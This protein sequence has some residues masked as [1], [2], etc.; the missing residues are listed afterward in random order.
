MRREGERSEEKKGAGS[1]VYGKDQK[2]KPVSF[3]K[4]KDDGTTKLQKLPARREVVIHFL[5]VHLERERQVSKAPIVLMH[6]RNMPILWDML[7]N[8]NVG[9]DCKAEK[10]KRLKPT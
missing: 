9:R 10:A 7:Y 5:L 1:A 6:G 8:Q 4:G 3:P 2:L